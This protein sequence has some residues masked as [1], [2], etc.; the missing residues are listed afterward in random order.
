MLALRVCLVALVAALPAFAQF[1]TPSAGAAVE[2]AARH[3]A[4]SSGSVPDAKP[5]APPTSSATV[6][7]LTETHGINIQPYLD[8]M[9]SRVRDEWYIAI[10]QYIKKPEARRGA[11]EAEFAIT[12]SGEVE[13]VRI[14]KSAADDLDRAVTEA[15]KNVSL[16]PIPKALP[17]EQ[18]RLRF[19][20]YYM[21]KKRPS[22]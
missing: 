10:H 19:H 9:L 4:P 7:V 18:I 11:V 17:M 22:W 20:F 14:T 1:K 8:V 6:E 12:R 15:L 5:K 2:D 13:G 3:S 21:G 16:P